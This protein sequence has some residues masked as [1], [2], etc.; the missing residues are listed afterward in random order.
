VDFTIVTPSY[1]QLDYLACNIASVADQKDV[2]VEHVIQDAGSEGF[3]EFSERLMKRWPDRP[4][5]RR[6]MISEPDRGMYDAVN[7]GLKRGTGKICAYLNCDEQYLP[8]ALR[9]IYEAFRS[10]PG[11]EICYGGFLVIDFRGNLITTQK[12]VGLFWPHVATSHLANFTC[13]TFFRRSLLERQQ[14]WFDPSYTACADALWTLERLRA[15]V[16]TIRLSAPVSAFRP[17]GT[18]RGLTQQSL[19]ERKRI[20]RG[21]PRWAQMGKPIWIAIHRL[22]KWMSGGYLPEK[23]EYS[24]WQSGDDAARVPHGPVWSHGIWWARVKL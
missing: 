11:A 2:S 4:N 12:P 10:A 7:K 17:T 18:N 21:A 13:A 19:E 1:R 6:L 3:N 23:I 9:R 22:L 20:A 24:I 16:A 8:G 5:Y 14:A 15:K